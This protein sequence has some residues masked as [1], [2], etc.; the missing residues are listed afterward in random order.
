MLGGGSGRVAAMGR[1]RVIILAGAGAAALFSASAA[2]GSAPPVSSHG[3]ELVPLVNPSSDPLE[4]VPLVPPKATPPATDDLEIAPLIPKKPPPV[5]EIIRWKKKKVT[6]PRQP[7]FTVRQQTFNAY[8]A[9]EQSAILRS[10]I[11]VDAEPGRCN[12]TGSATVVYFASRRPVLASA[13]GRSIS[14]P[15]LPVT[16]N[17]ASSLAY[18]PDIDSCFTLRPSSACRPDGQGLPGTAT[19]ATRGDGTT[20]RSL[21]LERLQVDEAKAGSACVDGLFGFP[22]VLGIDSGS[23]NAAIPWGAVGSRS[24]Q[25]VSIGKSYGTEGNQSTPGTTCTSEVTGYACAFS[26]LTKWNLRLVRAPQKRIPGLR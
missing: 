19:F 22:E 15:P 16:I 2:L 4:I 5:I 14:I 8:L 17:F 12:R 6:R 20:T 13:A 18:N 25:N 21:Y 3:V 10:T 1:W 7:N 9:G 23:E 26:S 24:Q 11:D